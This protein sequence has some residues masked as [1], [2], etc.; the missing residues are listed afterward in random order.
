[1]EQY[2]QAMENYKTNYPQFYQQLVTAMKEGQKEPA[3]SKLKD[4]LK[5]YKFYL[6]A[7]GGGV[8]VIIILLFLLLAR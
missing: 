2:N 6:A 5:E 8:V 3:S 4:F 7:I 1:M